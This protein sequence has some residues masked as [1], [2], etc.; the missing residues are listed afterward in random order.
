MTWLGQLHRVEQSSSFSPAV[1]EGSYKCEMSPT[2]E[3]VL[4]VTQSLTHFQF[5]SKAMSKYW[6]HGAGGR[7]LAPAN[8]WAL[9][10]LRTQLPTKALTWVEVCVLLG[11]LGLSPF[12]CFSQLTQTPTH[13]HT[14][15][16]T[17]QEPG[18][19]WAFRQ[20]RRVHCADSRTA[21]Q[22]V[23][24]PSPPNNTPSP[25]LGWGLPACWVTQAWPGCS[26]A[27]GKAPEHFPFSSFG[28]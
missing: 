21:S 10:W 24:T 16:H 28:C 26:P 22:V 9:R 6:S 12:F 14:H 8:A 1:G 27:P 20:G 25:R 23:R 5:Y 13:T 2:T 4:F 15:T 19:P 17:Q 3:V 18:E 7:H 11:L